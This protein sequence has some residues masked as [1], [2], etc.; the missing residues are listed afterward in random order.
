MEDIEDDTGKTTGRGLETVRHNEESTCATS[1]A[2]SAEVAEVAALRGM[3]QNTQGGLGTGIEII[4]DEEAP[5][6]PTQKYDIECGLQEKSK[7]KGCF[8]QQISDSEPMP[9]EAAAM[10]H[11]DSAVKDTVAKYRLQLSHSLHHY[12]IHFLY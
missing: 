8:K 4:D 11:D 3:G 7:I 1:Q 12:L 9:D 5:V 2:K 10:A 6:P